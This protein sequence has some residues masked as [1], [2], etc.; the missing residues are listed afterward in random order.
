MAMRRTTIV[1]DQ[2]LLAGAMRVT[3]LKSKS[4]VAN[5]ALRRLLRS[6]S[7]QGLRELRGAVQWEGDLDEM[8]R[9]HGPEHE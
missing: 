4:A 9:G 6:T 8:R 1:I 2:E 3:G 5:E 7:Y